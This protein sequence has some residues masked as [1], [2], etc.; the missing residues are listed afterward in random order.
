[1]IEP[2]NRYRRSVIS[3]PLMIVAP[4]PFVAALLAAIVAA[5]HCRLRRG[6]VTG[7][8]W[9]VVGL[10]LAFV[11]CLVVAWI[12]GKIQFLAPLRAQSCDYVRAPAPRSPPRRP[13]GRP[14]RGRDEAGYS[15]RNTLCKFR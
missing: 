2:G 13:S 8:G 11:G 1:M 7:A 12:W 15:R 4:G 6:K 3:D 10:V 5:I 14:G 9:S